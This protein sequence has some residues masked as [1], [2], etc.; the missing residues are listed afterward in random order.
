LKIYL[1]PSAKRVFFLGLNFLAILESIA[2][3]G[4]AS[5][6]FFL[7]K[8]KRYSGQQDSATNHLKI[9]NSNTFI[10]KTNLGMTF[11]WVLIS[12]FVI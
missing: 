1:R 7:S 6:F 2:L 9:T 3:M 12:K 11:G 10:M 4:T 5:F 8:R